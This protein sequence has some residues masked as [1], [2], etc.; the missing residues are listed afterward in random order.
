MAINIFRCWGFNSIFSGWWSTREWLRPEICCRISTLLSQCH[1][2]SLWKHNQRNQVT[3]CLREILNWTWLVC[4]VQP[5]TPTKIPVIARHWQTSSLVWQQ[6]D[7]NC[8]GHAKFKSCLVA[9]GSTAQMLAGQNLDL[10]GDIYYHTYGS[11]CA[12]K[13]LLNRWLWSTVYY[14]ARV[15]PSNYVI[16]FVISVAHSKQLRDL[17]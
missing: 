11:L 1:L 3:S 9:A 6:S 7:S 4:L 8:I 10:T 15:Q 5:G 14:K 17:G 2:V 13:C 12:E 16:T